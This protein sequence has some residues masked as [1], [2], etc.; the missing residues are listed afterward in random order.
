[1]ILKDKWYDTLKWTGLI[2]L[3]ALAVF[4][5]V[6]GE[7][8]GLPYVDEIVTTLNAVGVLI[9]TLIGVSNANYYKNEEADV[10]E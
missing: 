1:M 3:P 2:A 5:N 6:V 8:W 4:Y 9:G 7:A 10:N